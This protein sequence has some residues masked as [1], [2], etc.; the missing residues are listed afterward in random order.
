MKCNGEEQ[1]VPSARYGV[2]VCARVCVREV[3][4]VERASGRRCQLGMF[5]HAASGATIP[6]LPTSSTSP[7]LPPPPPHQLSNPGSHLQRCGAFTGKR[8]RKDPRRRGIR[9]AGGGAAK[10]DGTSG[11]QTSQS[12]SN[13]HHS[14]SFH[15]DLRFPKKQR[16]IR[17]KIGFMKTSGV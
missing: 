15:P 1:C 8:L 2:C 17:G 3:C 10:R 12:W 13:C 4:T 5:T 9:G 11:A 14:Q 6:H 16:W 7:R